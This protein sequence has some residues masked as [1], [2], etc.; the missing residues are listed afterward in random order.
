MREDSLFNYKKSVFL[1]NMAFLPLFSFNC[2]S[3]IIKEVLE[4]ILNFFHLTFTAQN[5]LKYISI[6]GGGENT[7]FR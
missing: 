2:Q 3:R 6:G 7:S 4:H 5:F 1:L